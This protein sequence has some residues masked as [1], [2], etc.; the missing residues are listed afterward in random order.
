M[1]SNNI[2]KMIKIV[3]ITIFNRVYYGLITKDNIKNIIYDV[4]ASD[5]IYRENDRKI[6]SLKYNNDDIQNIINEN[7]TKDI[8]FT[9]NYRCKIKKVNNAVLSKN[10]LY[11]MN[12]S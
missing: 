11:I 5:N 9:S 10:K 1:L 8:Y 7:K 2:I 4:I 6:Y 3:C 12:L